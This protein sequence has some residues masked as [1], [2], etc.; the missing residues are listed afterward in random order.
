MSTK[1]TQAQ[2]H[3]GPLLNVICVYSPAWPVDRGRLA[4]I[5]VSGVRLKQNRDVWVSDLLRA[6]LS[7][8]KLQPE[9]P[10]IVA[11]DFNLCETFD[12]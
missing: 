4:G 7:Y 11:G 8:M 5:D 12:A 10:W 9:E 6:A 2:L 1:S 3:G